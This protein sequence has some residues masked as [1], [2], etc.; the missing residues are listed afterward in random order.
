MLEVVNHSGSQFLHRNI[1]HILIVD[2]KFLQI[3]YASLPTQ[4][5][6]LADVTP[7]IL[8]LYLLVQLSERFAEHRRLLQL[9]EEGFFQ[10]VGIH[11]LITHHE[12]IVY[13]AD[14]G[15]DCVKIAVQF[16]VFLRFTFRL[17][18][19]RVP[20]GGGYIPVGI[21]FRTL[22]IHC[23][24]EGNGYFSLLVRPCLSRYE[25]QREIAFIG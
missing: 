5:R 14:L 21:Y 16:K 18:F 9:A 15:T 19:G 25:V 4:A 17:T 3:L 13:L 2:E 12:L 7:L 10:G 23:Y 8:V 6:T 11:H 20:V 24:S 22:P 1:F